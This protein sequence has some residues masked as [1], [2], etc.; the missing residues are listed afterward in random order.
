MSRAPARLAAA[1]LTLALAAPS[2]AAERPAYGGELRVALPLPPRISDPARA[3]E[4]PDR[5]LAGALHEPLLRATPAGLAPGLLEAVPAPLR[6]GRVFNLTLRE[7]LRFSDGSRL[8]A[9]NVVDLFESLLSPAHGSPHAWVAVAIQGAD[10]VLAGRARVPSG[11]RVL[12]ERELQVTLAFPFPGWPAALATLPASVVSGLGHGA[13]PFRREGIGEDE[14]AGRLVANAHHWRGR[15]YADALTFSAPDPR[16]G[17][18]A[19]E[20][21]QLDL[22]VRPEA[23]APGGDL[24]ARTLVYAAVNGRRLGAGAA[25]VRRVLAGLDRAELVRRFV[26]AAARPLD[27]LLPPGLEDAGVPPPALPPGPAPARLVVIAPGWQADPRAVA[28]RLQVRL[29]DAAMK[30]ALEPLQPAAYAARL[31]GGDWDVAL[32]AVPLQS[33]EP[34]LVAGQ[35]AQALGGPRAAQRAERALAGAPPGQVAAAAEAL[36]LELDLWPLFEA[37]H[38]LAWRPGVHAGPFTGDGALD[39]GDAW[40]SPAAAAPPSPPPPAAP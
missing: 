3:R 21:G 27:G 32:L 39:L 4:L 7:G 13:G 17:A 34:T 11:L 5:W 9:P 28:E 6:D 36:R 12:S 29:S 8:G 30:A 18:R 10:E 31:A 26:R 19:L 24:G 20:A 22:L 40:R 38:R 1:L 2:G 35:V 25:A 33:L 23:G 37:G 15:P 14:H 16:T